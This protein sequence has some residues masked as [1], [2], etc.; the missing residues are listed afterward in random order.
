MR[1]QDLKEVDLVVI[2]GTK[3]F[4]KKQVAHLAAA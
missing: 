4:A 1:Q 3:F 2:E